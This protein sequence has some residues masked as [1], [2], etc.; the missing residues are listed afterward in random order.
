MNA[1]IA[2]F[3]EL[4]EFCRTNQ[5]AIETKFNRKMEFTEFHERCY[6]TMFNEQRHTSAPLAPKILK[7]KVEGLTEAYKKMKISL[8]ESATNQ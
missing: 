1:D 3:K 8:S 7:E 5:E 2:L 4:L 6:E